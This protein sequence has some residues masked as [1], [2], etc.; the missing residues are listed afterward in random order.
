MLTRFDGHD[1]A[2]TMSDEFLVLRFYPLSDT[3][4]AQEKLQSAA[5]E[6]FELVDVVPSADAAMV[7]M[8]RRKRTAKSATTNPYRPRGE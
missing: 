4:D 2:A 7:I 3:E 5:D 8:K 6:G 1:Y